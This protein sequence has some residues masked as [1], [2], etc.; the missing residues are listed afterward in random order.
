MINLTNS[1]NEII[2]YSKFENIYLWPY[3]LPMDKKFIEILE[4]EQAS[5]I[6]FKPSFNY[7]ISCLPNC[8]KKIIFPI[9]SDFNQPLTN[10]PLELEELEL[11][12][13][14]NQPLNYLPHGLKRLI[15]NSDFNHPIDNLPNTLEYLE[16]RG[17][18]NHS[19]DNLPNNLKMLVIKDV[20]DYDDYDL[21]L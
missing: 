19:L 20:Y 14:F 4:V 12:D 21:N 16:I 9:N 2:M 7:D 8:I 18:F 5:I 15:I 1:Q 3:G 11:Y 10:L 6:E 13:K 17:E